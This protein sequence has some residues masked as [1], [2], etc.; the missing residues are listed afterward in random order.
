MRVVIDTNVLMSGLISPK[1]P[2]AQIVRAWLDG[3]FLLLYTP[4]MLAEWE[5]VLARA[6]LA[7]RLQ[8]AP[9]RGAALLAALVQFGEVVLGY[10]NVAG[11]V[12]DPFDEMFLACA[13]LGHADYL[14][15]GDKALLMLGSY[16]TTQIV[17]P[18]QFM[19]RFQAQRAGADE[20][21]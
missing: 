16:Q 13:G 18:A 9:A 17:T 1:G 7:E 4:A 19:Q 15:T 21:P 12:R 20:Q 2:P 8:R 11:A 3:A 6:W 10:L 14:V 5:D